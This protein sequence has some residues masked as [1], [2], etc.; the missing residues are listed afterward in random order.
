MAELALPVYIE[1]ARLPL[2]QAR[3]SATMPSGACVA[4]IVAAHYE[5]AMHW[6]LLVHLG[7]EEVQHDDWQKVYAKAG[8]IVSIQ[9]VAGEAVAVS[10]LIAGIVTLINYK[11]APKPPEPGEITRNPGLAGDQNNLRPYQPMPVAFGTS[12]AAPPLANA[13]YPGVYSARQTLTGLLFWTLGQADI[14]DIRLDETP[15]VSFGHDVNLTTKHGVGNA[16]FPVA[17]RTIAVGADLN[18]PGTV[19]RTIG[20]VVGSI[21][22]QFTAP[23][24][25]YWVEKSGEQHAE[26]L[27]LTV[28]LRDADS[29]ELIVSRKVTLAGRAGLAPWYGHTW[30]SLADDKTRNLE[31]IVV[32]TKAASTTRALRDI[33]IASVTARL[34]EA[35]LQV[36]ATTTAAR[37]VA[38]SQLSGQLPVISGL[39]SAHHP[40]WD[41]ISWSPRP[42]RSPA[43]AFRAVLTGAGIA[44]PVPINQLHEPSLRA[45]LAYC[46]QHSYYYDATITEQRSVEDLLT[47]IAAAAR[48]VPAWIDGKRGVIIDQVRPARV[49]LFSG[50]N[51]ASFKMQRQFSRPVPHGLRGTYR[52]AEADYAATE[53]KVYR[54][55]YSSSTATLIEEHSL[56]GVTSQMQAEK[57]LSYQL[58]MRQHRREIYEIELDWEH[59]VATRGDRVGLQHDTIQQASIAARVTEITH[60]NNQLYVRFDVNIDGVDLSLPDG[61]PAWL[62]VRRSDTVKRPQPLLRYQSP[63]QSPWYNI[64]I[65]AVGDLVLL[66]PKNEELL[67]CIIQDIE[68]G[69]DASARLRLVPYAAAALGRLTGYTAQRTTSSQFVSAVAFGAEQSH[70]VPASQDTAAVVLQKA[71]QSSS[72]K[73]APPASV[74]AVADLPLGWSAEPAGDEQISWEIQR[75]VTWYPADIGIPADQIIRIPY[76]SL[77]LDADRTAGVTVG[78]WSVPVRYTGPAAND[79]RG[80]EW[81]GAWR[82]GVG[83]RHNSTLQDVVAYNSKSWI[84]QQTHTA[85]NANRPRRAATAYW[86]LL[87]DKGQ[88]GAKGNS[89]VWQGAWSASTNYAIRDTVSHSRSSWIATRSSRGQTPSASSSHWNLLADKGGDG[90]PGAD[91]RGFEWRGAW[92]SGVGYRHSSTLQDVVSHAGKS[93]VCTRGHTATQIRTPSSSGGNAYWSLLADKGQAGLKGDSFAWRGTWSA[94]TNYAI[95]DTVSHGRRSWIATRSSRGQ[96]PSASSSHW[97]LLADKGGDGDPGDDGRGFEWRGAWR[98]GVGYRHNS[99]LQDVVAYN[100][101]SWICQ[102]THT[103]TNAN[104]PRRAATA[105]WS[106]LADKG[107]AGLKGDSFVWQGAWSASTN[108]AIRDTVSHSRSSWIATRSSR[109]QTPSAS[110]SHW[111]L[112]ADKGGDGDPGADGRGFEWRGAWRSGV[113]YRHS[114]TL[115]DVVSHAGKSWVC[116]R[117]H[118]ATQIRTPSSSGG[119]AYWSL[120]ADKGQAGLK[121]DSF[122]WQGAWSASTNYAIR[123]TV[124][125]SRSSWIA[126]RSSRGQ[127]PSASSSHWN[128]LADKGGDGDPGADGRGFEWRGAWRSG[129]GYRHSSTLQDVVSHAG[130]SWVCTRGH[131]ATQIRTPSSSGGNAYWSLLAD[132]GQAG[133]KGDSFAWRGTWSAS[134]NYA[135]RDTVSHGRRSWIATR[136]SRGQTPS[137]NSGYW[138]LLADKGQ[139]GQDSISSSSHPAGRINR[140]NSVEWQPASI[141]YAVK[142][143][144]SGRVIATRKVVA[145]PSASPVALNYS[146]SVATGET[147]RLLSTGGATSYGS[148]RSTDVQHVL[149][150]ATIRLFTALSESFIDIGIGPA[151]GFK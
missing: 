69:P 31:L 91:G 32:R 129:V 135:I 36:K 17:V 85:T 149:S 20:R 33:N 42:T 26:Q 92:R 102:Q 48:A 76:A 16:S 70:Q 119:N 50:I 142:F 54:P 25:L 57:L 132:K 131:T 61:M 89:F 14:S 9:V 101:K 72:T 83:Y 62:A 39:I 6:L 118:T 148:G 75:P 11:F 47:E 112:L 10:L 80:F 77:M 150:G 96:T 56:A 84:C 108:Y 60:I 73:P 1:G 4:E 144:R 136:S 99:T 52:D 104:R 103:A 15:A 27:P 2:G 68:P 115:Q 87:A 121:G 46:E 41:G 28:Q 113:G 7:G 105:Y 38:A 107:Q 5:P 40:H 124:S 44:R 128:L 86:S 90:D 51:I 88:P 74:D 122:V 137:A 151:P 141:T 147:T 98:S 37:V 79:G 120:L 134:T 49:Q 114:S 3:F 143:F 127:T 71:Y 126:T 21:Q 8:Q 97:N 133:L 111:N 109:G 146:S 125:H 81:R 19:K 24:G 106:L 58:A 34:T 53:L 82:A 35:A 100:S 12:R 139:D 116:T 64:G 66:G 55:G 65:A 110:S 29:G 63:D 138:S 95:R 123:D 67:D 59:L 30:V 94:S 18:E 130:K 117:G 93:W 78:D 22:I 145:S 23:R 45:W 13:W 43:A 140:Y